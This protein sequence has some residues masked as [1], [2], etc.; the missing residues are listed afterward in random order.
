MFAAAARRRASK[1]YDYVQQPETIA[2]ALASARFFLYAGS[3]V[4]VFRTYGVKP[5][6]VRRL[7][8]QGTKHVAY[9]QHVGGPASSGV[10]LG[11]C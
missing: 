1:F 4:Y 7:V 10:L 5:T 3:A 2:E 11:V 8:M 6:I 9:V